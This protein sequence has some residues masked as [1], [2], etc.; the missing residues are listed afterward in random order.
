MISIAIMTELNLNDTYSI[1][2]VNVYLTVFSFKSILKDGSQIELFVRI[3]EHPDKYLPNV[4]NL[5]FGPLDSE[6]EIDDEIVLNHSNVGKVLSTVL[7]CGI[8][9]LDAMHIGTLVGVDGSNDVRA[10]LY[11]RMFQTNHKNLS[12]VITSVGV[13]WY[14]KLLRNGQDIERDSNDYPVFKPRSEPF[15][16]GRLSTDYI[17]TICFP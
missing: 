8:T 13:D 2:Y 12:K 14:V 11:H 17:G 1:E 6:G 4:Y 15:D 7:L 3:T 10:Y 9:F 5:G 16:S